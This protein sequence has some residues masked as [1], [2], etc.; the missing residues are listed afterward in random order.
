MNRRYL[1]VT[2]I[3]LFTALWSVFWSMYVPR[4]D[5]SFADRIPLEI[6]NW[7]GEEL[8]IPQD[9]LEILE[10][11]DAIMRR[12]SKGSISIYLWVV[13]T[14]ENRKAIHPMEV[15]YTSSGWDIG[16]KSINPI[17]VWYNGRIF[18]LPCV[19]LTAY[20]GKEK[21][22]VIYFYKTGRHFT[23]NYYR[24][25]LNIILDQLLFRQSPSAL[26]G[27]WVEEKI[28][29]TAKVIPILEDFIRE[30]FPY[31]ASL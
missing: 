25:Q 24:Q 3:L 30:L 5:I 22:F 4:V 31:I 2:S 16:S 20:K 27:V 9:A 14:R 6:G 8:E 18:K 29:D 26:I 15:C 7:Y 12:Y 13:F 19:R 28:L 10:T 21:G 11:T 17:E 1:I 23:H